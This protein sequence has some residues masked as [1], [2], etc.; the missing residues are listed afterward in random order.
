MNEIAITPVGRESWPAC[1]QLVR[2]VFEFTDAE[3]IPAWYMHTATLF[4]SIA[5]VATLGDA[6]VGFGIAFP[7]VA[8]GPCLFLNQLCV[9]PAHRSRGI[10]LRLLA[11]IRDA[12]R[13]ERWETMR[14]TTNAINSQNLYLYLG[15][16]RAQLVGYHPMMYRG[17]L[18]RH[19][20]M[21]AN[22]DEVEIEWDLGANTP[23]DWFSRRQPQRDVIPETVAIPTEPTG[24]DKL[25]IPTNEPSALDGAAR[26]YWVEVPWDAERLYET[27]PR[28]CLAWREALRARIGTLLELGYV[29]TDSVADPGERRSFIVFERASQKE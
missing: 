27:R 16:C 21:G 14:W 6:T 22:G 23:D 11:A 7:A 26:S 28:D 18:G 9:A 19:S 10:A 5:R 12:A 29:G 8:G 15:R 13:D 2:E 25:R 4:G 20:G 1:E 24:E 3:V 17:L